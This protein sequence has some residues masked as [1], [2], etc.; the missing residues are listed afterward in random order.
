M[1]F[2]SRTSKGLPR[3]VPMLKEGAGVVTTRSHAHWIVTEYGAANLFGRDLQE[4]AEMLIELAH[5]EDRPDL[6]KF[7][8]QRFP[9]Y[10]RWNTQQESEAE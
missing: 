8:R 10:T 5:P 1:A 2:T 3:I 9:K 7:V 6:W 4:R